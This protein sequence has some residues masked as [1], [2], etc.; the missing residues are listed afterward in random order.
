MATQGSYSITITAIDKSTKILNDFN[1]K[2]QAQQAPMKALSKSWG[3]FSELSGLNKLKAGLGN[4]KDHIMSI[5]KGILGVVSS[6]GLLGG[7][8]SVGGA[9]S[10]LRTF[11]AWGTEL[12]NTSSRLGTTIEQ[13]R[14]FRSAA[15]LAGGS[16]QAMD[17]SIESLGQ[18]A[19]DALAGRDSEA[20][21]LFQFYGIN[22]RKSGMIAKDGVALMGEAFDAIQRLS[23]AGASSATV[24][25]AMGQFGI[26]PDLY[27]FAIQG[28]SGLAKYNALAQ[29]YATQTKGDVDSADNMRLGITKLN[30]AFESFGYKLA[31]AVSPAVTGLINEFADWLSDTNKNK[32]AM[33]DISQAV[34]DFATWLKTIQWSEVKQGLIDFKNGILFVIN[35]IKEMIAPIKYVFGLFG[36]H[37]TTIGTLFDIYLIFKLRSVIGLL[38]KALKLSNQLGK[39]LPEASTLGLGAGG[40]LVS[41]LAPIAGAAAAGALFLGPAGGED[42][43]FSQDKNDEFIRNRDAARGR[44]PGRRTILQTPEYIAQE[45]ARG[46]EASPSSGN[47]KPLLDAIGRSEGTIRNPGGAYNATYGFGAYGN[48]KGMNLTN[49]TIEQIEQVQRNI[50]DDPRNTANTSAIGKYQFEQGTLKNLVRQL[51]ISQSTTFSPQLQD[52]LAI[53]DMKNRGSEEYRA[54]TSNRFE[55]GMGK[56]WDSWQGGH[57]PNISAAEVAQLMAQFKNS[58]DIAQQATAAATAAN[59]AVD[60]SIDHRNVPPNVS[61]SARTRGNDANLNIKSTPLPTSGVS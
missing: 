44:P 55:S 28:A 26:S 36:I 27:R 30:L 51:G 4:L 10:L 8:L 34:S 46:S 29:Q 31:T 15:L 20:L 54:G 11:A 6:F 25:R 35:Q 37:L 58:N 60:I 14:N 5:G 23:Q 53:Q 52:L 61:M 56:E 42:Q 24:S 48:T 21:R 7:A 49:Q 12:K 59:T 9:I 39:A 43:A 50:H 1:K 13:L 38:G 2:L 57:H 22:V 45:A 19:Q 33:D 40:G 3:K 16:A 18:K 17:S 32:N 41:R 47:Y